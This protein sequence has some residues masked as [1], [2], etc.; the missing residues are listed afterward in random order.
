MKNKSKLTGALAVGGGLKHAVVPYIITGEENNGYS[1]GDILD[2]NAVQEKIN[3]ISFN[4]FNDHYMWFFNDWKNGAKYEGCTA[5]GDRSYAE[6]ADTVSSEYCSHAEGGSTTASGPISHAEGGGTTASGPVSHAEG[7]LTT[8]S[9]YCSHAEGDLTTAS[10]PVS[11]AE[12]SGTTAS[13]YGSHAEGDHTTSVGYASHAE[14]DHTTSV[15]YASHAEGVYTKTYNTAEHA[16]G[17]YNISN[18]KSDQS[19]QTLF[20]IGNGLSD[21]SRHNAFEIKAN[22]DV[23]VS[24]VGNYYNTTTTT[25]GKTLQTVVNGKQ[26]ILTAGDNITISGTTISAT[27]PS[28]YITSYNNVKTTPTMEILSNGLYDFG[29][30][31]ALNLTLAT[32]SDTTILNEYQFQFSCGDTPATLTLPSTVKWQTPIIIQANCTYQVR[33]INNLA[34]YGEW[35]NS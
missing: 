6:G 1:K 29:T 17:K 10:G 12:G 20:S 9:E 21:A 3:R 15:G 33:I 11:H 22:G 7:N 30:Q 24:G 35:P 5:S 19:Q 8:A 27:I 16:S 14:G 26:D 34:V 4:V 18:S 2:A 32:P 13:E 23:Y 31:T 28:K 25:T